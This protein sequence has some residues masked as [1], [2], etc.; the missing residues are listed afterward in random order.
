MIIKG[1][2]DWGANKNGWDF[3]STDKR[4]KSLIKD[5][6]QAL[7]CENAFRTFE[8]IVSQVYGEE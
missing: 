1:I 2:C 3:V 6:V 4:E 7:C 5:C 8:F